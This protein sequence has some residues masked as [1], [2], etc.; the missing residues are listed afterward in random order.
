MANSENSTKNLYPDI[1]SK[2]NFLKVLET[3][4]EDISSAIAILA[5]LIMASNSSF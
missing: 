1:F 4:T 2:G 5:L 3:H